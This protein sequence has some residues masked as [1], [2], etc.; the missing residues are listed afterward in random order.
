MGKYQ[1]S[2]KRRVGICAMCCCI[3]LLSVLLGFTLKQTLPAIFIIVMSVAL[4]SSCFSLVIIYG[5]ALKSENCLK[6]LYIREK[7]ERRNFIKSKTVLTGLYVTLGGLVLA[8]LAF[9]YFNHVVFFTLAG[10]I[11]FIGGVMIVLKLYYSHR[12]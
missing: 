12:V 6:S 9:S 7:D 10:V 11:L 4:Q 8:M 5:T 3:L 2:L 1:D